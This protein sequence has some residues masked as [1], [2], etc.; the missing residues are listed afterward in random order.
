MI[1]N[2]LNQSSA[3]VPLI[4]II[5]PIFQLIN[6]GRRD[7]FK[8]AFLSLH[9]Q[10]NN[11]FEHIIVDGASTDGTNQFIEELVEGLPNKKTVSFISE[12][13][14]G[15]YEAMNKGAAIAKG[16]YLMFLNS[17]DYLFDLN[18]INELSTIIK[19]NHPSYIYGYQYSLDETGAMHLW[20]RMSPTCI[21]NQM[22]FGYASIL[23]NRKMFETLNGHDTQ[24]KICADY[25]LMLRMIR[26]GY[27]G[28]RIKKPIGVFRYGG[29]SADVQRTSQE[30]TR[31]W[32]SELGTVMDLTEVEDD[33]ILY[34]IQS[35]KIPLSHLWSAFT[36]PNTSLEWKRA[37]MHTALKTIRRKLKLKSGHRIKL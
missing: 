7:T 3:S 16:K 31:V 21:F 4:S 11:E 32:R 12:P 5:S 26:R 13:D 15:L 24:Y 22:P 2:N 17:D 8:Q 6:S 1:T 23:L 10:N 29:I 28:M 18:I 35:G 25:D 30:H 27:R 20:R 37:C 34:W 9:N 33:E 14:N 36:H 19:S